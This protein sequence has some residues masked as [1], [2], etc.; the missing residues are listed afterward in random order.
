[1]ITLELN[2]HTAEDAKLV[3]DLR[4]Q[5]VP[6]DVIQA[7]YNNTQAKRVDR[8]RGDLISR[9][10]LLR[11]LRHNAAL[12]TDENGETRQL[13][14]VDIH[15]LIEYVEKMPTAFDVDET[16]EELK[17]AIPLNGTLFEQ[18]FHAALDEVKQYGRP[19]EHVVVTR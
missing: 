5:G 2:S 16:V 19:V 18:G 13:V 3:Q 17:A 12:H 6:E 11:V 1:M 8:P 7:A 4:R 9:S 10:E 14:A 15:K